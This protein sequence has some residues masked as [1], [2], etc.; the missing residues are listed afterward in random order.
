VFVA[1]IDARDRRPEPEPERRRRRR[2]RP[3]L[4]D[5]PWRGLAV[6]AVLV[7][8]FAAA[9]ATGGIVAYVLLLVAV[10][11]GSLAVD[12][13]FDSWSGMSEHRQ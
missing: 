13:S 1:L 11:V 5:V 9:N 10:V 4:D 7:A 8:L 3:R 2:R 6:V 12:A